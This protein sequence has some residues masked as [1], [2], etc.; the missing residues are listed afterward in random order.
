[1]SATVTMS[2]RRLLFGGRQAL[3]AP[4][5]G[6]ETE[7]AGRV[8]VVL[9]S[10]LEHRGVTCRS[11]ETACDPLAIRFRPRPGGR[12]ELSIDASRCNACG[13][14]IDLCPVGALALAQATPSDADGAAR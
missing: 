6:V 4:G 13:Q 12:S 1:M 3:V 11:C 2:R 14:C 10:C 9:P 7:T 8:A 5:P